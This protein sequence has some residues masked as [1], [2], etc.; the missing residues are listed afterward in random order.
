MTFLTMLSP[1]TDPVGAATWPPSFSDISRLVVAIIVLVGAG[2]LLV[3]PSHPISAE[4]LVGV[5]AV[6]IGYYF[7]VATTQTATARRGAPPA[8]KEG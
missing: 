6:I 3:M 7:G 5:V 8:P 2:V 1:E 4:A